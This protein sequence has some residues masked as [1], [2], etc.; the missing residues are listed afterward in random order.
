M[1]NT[2]QVFIITINTMLMTNTATHCG[3][4][5]LIVFVQIIM[6]I[7]MKNFDAQEWSSKQIQ[8]TLT[9]SIVSLKS[10]WFYS[11]ISYHDFD[12]Y[13]DVSKL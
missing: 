5:A 1:I 10:V 4:R 2:I 13:F 7:A 11:S 3:W 9:S 8:P 6:L 12:F